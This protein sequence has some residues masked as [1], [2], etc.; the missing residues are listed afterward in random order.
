VRGEKLNRKTYTTVT[1]TLFLL[2]GIVHLV[3]MIFGWKAEIGGL[4]IPF[5]VSWLALPFT[6]ALA[7]FGFTQKR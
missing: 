4:S 7:Y 1:A 2:M 6:G 5:W 3:R